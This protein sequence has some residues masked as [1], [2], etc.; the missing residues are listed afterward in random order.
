NS[1]Y[2]LCLFPPTFVWAD[3]VV[4]AQLGEK[5]FLKSPSSYNA[6]AHYIYW[7]FGKQ[8]PS[9]IQLG[10]RN[11]MGGV[12]KTDDESWK[13][14]ITLSENSLIIDGIEEKHFGTYICELKSGGEKEAFTYEL[15][16]VNVKMNM[17]SP[18][19]L[20]PGES[21]SLDCSVKASYRMTKIHW[22]N[23]S[24]ES[25]GS[26]QKAIIKTAT[27]KDNGQWTCV[28][29]D[30]QK[31]YQ[32]KISVTVLDLDPASSLFQ[33]SSKSSHLTIPCSIPLHISWDQ[34]KAKGLK[35]V[36]WQFFPKLP[37]GGNSDGPQQLFSLYLDQVPLTWKANRT[38]GLSTEPDLQKGK[39]SLVRK[40]GREGDRGD[41]VCSFK[42]PKVTL[43][44]TVHLEV[45][46]IISSPGT[47]LISGQQVNLTCSLGHPLPSDLQVKWLP[48]EGS[49][50]LSL[51]S[52]PH[53]VHLSIPEI[54]T[55]DSGN[56]ECSLWQ[57]GRKLTSDVITLKIE[58][59][60]S[61]WML[62]IICSAAVIVILLLIVVFFL[63]RRRQRRMRHL[64]HRL[65]Q[66]KRYVHTISW[67]DEMVPDIY[68]QSH[69]CLH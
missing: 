62:V 22:L 68:L 5:V 50:Q 47:N 17:G 21:L 15:F 11:I 23:P 48:P 52:D 44:K 31:E 4:Y 59:K 45:L 57:G 53:P 61:V 34:I 12:G 24:G 30:N 6:T 40:Q 65:C 66:C 54:W 63:Y 28:V 2:A 10:W 64:R 20:L 37:S 14:K 60:L 51:Q 38:R 7:F 27:S 67:T 46:Q 36:N 55:E 43:N 39:L 9:R 35:E 58:P 25:I 26:N 32:A 18:S 69:S 19:L 3:E 1:A 13:T 56:W 41:Y 8:E 49:S 42:F 16:Q 29:R 33:Y